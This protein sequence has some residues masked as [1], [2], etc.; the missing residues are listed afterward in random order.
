MIR[1]IISGGQ[2]GV[3]RSA[4]DF[5]LQNNIECGGWCPKDR[6]AEDGMIPL[7]YPLKETTE[8]DSIF[9]THKNIIEADGTLIIFSKIMDEGTSRTK[10][11]AEKIKFANLSGRSF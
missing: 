5:C 8:V 9:R 11:Y 2:T 1:K 3:D 10:L 7:K 4:L 6:I